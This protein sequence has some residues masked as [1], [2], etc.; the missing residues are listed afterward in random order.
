M[1]VEFRL[2]GSIEAYVD[3]RPLD[4]GPA[5]QRSLLAALLADPNR[6][7][8]A[9]QLV[10][11]VWGD[12]APHRAR[13]TLRT[14]LSR[15][16]QALAV[17]DEVSIGR[18]A[19]GYVL[20]LDPG[21]VDLHH[22][23]Q[24]LAMA[25][26]TGDGTAAMDL[27]DQALA[28]WRGEP[29]AQLDT[30]W[31][32]AARTEAENERT[33]AELDRT[34]LLLRH[35]RHHELPAALWAQTAE[36]P[37][38][39][40]LA[41]QLMLALYRNGRQADALDRYQ[42]IR[43]RL[44]E[45]LGADPSP[46]LQRLHQ[47]ILTADPA[48]A[49]PTITSAATPSPIPR[50]LPAPP[51]LF[52][53]RTRELRALTAALD[54]PAAPGDRM[55]ISAI[56]GTGGIGKTWLALHWAHQQAERFPDGQL[57]V[58]LRG[59][60]PGTQPVSPTM[61]V[62]GFLDALGVVPTA[63]PADPDAQAALYRSLVAGKRMLVV[64]DN[65]A[66]SSQVIPLL[67]GDST[68]AVLITSR[69][70]LTSL[71]VTHGAR[72]ILLDVLGH[73]E[74]RDLLMRH[75]GAD[76][77]ATEPEVAHDLLRCCGGLPL[78][79]GIVAARVA[80]HPG[81]ALSMFAQELVDHSTRLD[82]LDAGEADL[83][84]RAVF[85]WSYEALDTD[86]ADL[87]GLLS[88]V[89]GPDISL[90][91]AASLA[92]LPL[93]RA[94]AMLR[95]L[96]TA[97]LIQQH[98]PGRYR[99]HDLIRAYAAEQAHRSLAEA[100]RVAALRRLVDFYVHTAYAGDRLQ[101]QHREPISLDVPV[102]GCRPEPLADQAAALSWFEAEH[103]CLLAAHRLADDQRWDTSVWQLAWALR[104]F[105]RRRGH[106]HEDLALWQVGLVA[107]ERLGD[108][109]VQI[110][111]HRFLGSTWS[112]LGRHDDAHRHLEHALALAE[113]TGDTTAE[114]HIHMALG[115]VEKARGASR[116]A[117]DHLTRAA[118]LYRTLV[119]PVWEADALTTAGWFHAEAG[120]YDE[121]LTECE[122]ALRI[123]RKHDEPEGEADTL[124]SLGYIAHHTG[125]YTAALE[126]YEQARVLFQGLGYSSNEADTLDR[127]GHTQV[128][129]DRPDQARRSW[130]QA[131]S[132]YQAQQRTTDAERVQEQLAE[133]DTP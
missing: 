83:S 96:D 3:E 82:A 86:A 50:Q 37:L 6:P 19:G 34:D 42:D 56:G 77:L 89:P 106:G 67:P 38:D 88:L 16:R 36:R 61:A 113:H 71:V 20:T 57:Y 91:A 39:E 7:V 59:F 63:I 18:R 115:W 46:P 130:R 53:G 102:D 73:T 79:L 120:R 117:A 64:L 49:P 30:P 26:S 131:L 70:K 118:Q 111:A 105:H 93:A 24:L 80:A 116:P 74:A 81:R 78:A 87:L 121:A 8:S 23:H 13:E 99:M 32:R 100:T 69:N 47:Q 124:S 129:L 35:G 55:P 11:R 125:R 5:R 95:R 107:A 14:Y 54:E 126:L 68:C 114:A 94:G 2:L 15:L 103:A 51:Q 1:A 75:L 92:A 12:H 48:L 25:R 84:V 60:A 4:I 119:N 76:R 45:E 104:T 43:T 72:L 21:I 90:S 27:F 33:R 97:H 9:D 123:Y 17:T 10:E 31:S 108:L 66:S 85:S 101:Q 110:Q 127:L 58:N 133:L 40:R 29:F 22:F 112:E 44:A 52:T 62:R 122:D 98:L 128:A 132:I 65:A 28:L 109:A 41:G